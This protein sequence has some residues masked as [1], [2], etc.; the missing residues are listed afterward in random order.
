MQHGQRRV[1]NVYVYVYV[2]VHVDVYVDV[3]V[4]V[5]VH[6][7]VYGMALGP[8]HLIWRNSTTGEPT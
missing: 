4:Y 7:H 8:R 5:Y 1:G 6:V 3:Y 2:Y